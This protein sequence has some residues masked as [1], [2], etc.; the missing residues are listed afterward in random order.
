MT[1]DELQPVRDRTAGARVPGRTAAELL[2]TSSVLLSLLADFRAV[3]R[4]LVYHQPASRLVPNTTG[5]VTDPEYWVRHVRE[6]VWFADG[7]RTLAAHGV[8]T[9]LELGPDGV[10]SAL[11]QES[12]DQA[13]PL[14]RKDK[15][16]EQSALAALAAH[17][18][19]GGLGD[20]ELQV[21]HLLGRKRRQPADGRQGKPGEDDVV[22]LGWD[23]Q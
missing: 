20:G 6:T 8:T 9:V 7:V 23:G 12:V 11:A 17:H 4:G 1:V 3:A 5:D 16:E 14:L 2:L 10:L 19:R 21:G 13:V 18:V 15:P 22:G